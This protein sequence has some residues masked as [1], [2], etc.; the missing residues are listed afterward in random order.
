MRACHTR[1]PGHERP[2]AQQALAGQVAP[3]GWAALPVV[4]ML[5]M[6]GLLYSPSLHAGFIWDD[7]DFYITGNPLLPL[8]DGLYRI[9]FTDEPVDYYPLV[10]STWWFAWRAFHDAPMGYHLINI[11]LHAANG[12]LLWRVLRALH[13]PG[14]WFAAAL[15]AVHPVNVET[16]TWIAQLKNILPMFFTLLSLL[17]YLRFESTAYR[18]YY[19][20]SFVCFALAL[21]GKPAGA[22]FPGVLLG[23]VSWRQ[24]SLTWKNV[25][26]CVPFLALSIV[27][28]LVTIHFQNAHSLRGVAV[29]PDSVATRIAL[30]GRCILF[31]LRQAL[32]PFHLVFV[33]PRWTIDPAAPSAWWPWVALLLFVACAWRFRSSWGA[34]CLAALGYFVLNLVPVLG[35]FPV[36]FFRYSYVADHWQY[37]ALIGVTTCIGMLGHQVGTRHLHSGAFVR[38]V[39]GALVL[40]LLSVLTWRQQAPYK[41]E[42]D[43]WRDTVTRNPAAWLAAYNLGNFQAQRGD[44]ES[45]IALYR[46]A[47]AHRADYADA[48]A[49][50]GNALLMQGKTKEALAHWEASLRIDPRMDQV[51]YNMALTML[52]LGGRAEAQEHLHAAL[53]VNPGNQAARSLLQERFGDSGGPP[54]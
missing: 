21:L 35:V 15:W 47:L 2:G 53:R 44:Y 19:M 7:H 38:V 40:G 13:V 14:A 9:W 28:G 50:L 17:A 31:Y 25:R 51:H 34:L 12:V 26:R 29:L 22:M 3:T 42:E 37:F 27:A 46:Q 6:I 20:A 43:L 30:A 41:T 54:S 49:N 33:Y 48:E 1:L 4:C 18:R 16:V 8:P 11:L 52:S 24:R 39:C 45:A 23:L 10:Y 36:F 32:W 5:L